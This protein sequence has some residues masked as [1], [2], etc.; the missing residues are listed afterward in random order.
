MFENVKTAIYNRRRLKFDVN[1]CIID[2]C[3]VVG[4]PVQH[5]LSIV[6]N[7]VCRRM[8]KPYFQHGVCCNSS[9]RQNI[10]T[11]FSEQDIKMAVFWVATPCSMLEVYRRF[12]GTCCLHHQP[13]W[14]QSVRTAKKSQHFTITKINWLTL[15]REI[16]AVYSENHTK[17]INTKCRVT[18]C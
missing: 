16:I 3:P 4:R 6:C 10:V 11:S 18:D 13:W 12:R 5:P 15:F 14:W 8:L 9:A 2:K 7:C 1:C 17:H